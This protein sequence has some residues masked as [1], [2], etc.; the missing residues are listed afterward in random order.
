MKL[1]KKDLATGMLEVRLDSL[2]DLW[3]LRNLIQEGDLVTAD[4][5]RTG[6][7]ATDQVRAGKAEKKPMR[8]GIRVKEVS[9]HDFA[10]H[11][12][13]LGVI[14]EG[15]QDHGSH[16]TLAFT[17][18]PGTWLRIHKKGGRLAGWQT[19]LIEEA[20][21]AAKRPQ[22][23]LVA[24]DDTE[25]QFGLLKS[26]G[27]QLLGSL[28]AGGQGKRYSNKGA[29]SGFYDEVVRSLKVIRQEP[30]TPL[31]IVGPGWWREEF[32]EHAQK[33]EPAAVAGAQTDGTSQGGRGGLQEAL[34]RGLVT[35]V[36]RDSRV[37][38][39][40]DLVERLM[41]SIAKGD[42]LCAYGP[43]DVA[44]AVQAGAAEEVLVTDDAVR[45]G[46]H[47]AVLQDADRNRAHVRVVATSHD[48]GERLGQLGGLAALLRFGI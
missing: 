21:A 29:K 5:V 7:Q 25:A 46:K 16:H 22:V 32:I 24:I 47:D 42:G 34:R 8:L 45:S 40:T 39:E 30:D 27:L 14:E 12:R 28:P 2:D 31:L 33:K 11:L 35:A 9:W 44:A 4:T 43:A 13:V 48:A 26:Y 10:D 37:A 20:E 17:D 19:K 18:E 15:P 41:A 36:A 6:E 1:T 3:T 23:V 38:Q